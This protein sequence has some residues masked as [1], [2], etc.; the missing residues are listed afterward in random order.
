MAE[1]CAG[2]G[3]G[4]GIA[5]GDMGV[6]RE[7]EQKDSYTPGMELTGKYVVF[8]EGARGGAVSG[9]GGIR[10]RSSLA[11]TAGRMREDPVFRVAAHHFLRT[12]DKTFAE[13]E[14]NASDAELIALADSRTARAFMLFGRVAGVF[15]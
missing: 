15:D 4:L 7:G 12:F 1:G 5:T 13:F 6:S 2:V 10:D 9:L 11:L 3:A 14:K 8:A